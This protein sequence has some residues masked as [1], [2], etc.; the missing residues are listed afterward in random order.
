MVEFEPKIIAFC[1]HYCAYAAADLAG[2]M[3]MKYPPNVRIIRLPCTGKLDVVYL[4]KAFENKADGVMVV[5]CEKGS[6][7][8]TSGNLRAEKRVAYAKELLKEVGIE[9][10]RLEMYFLSSSMAGRFVQVVN[11][12]TERIKKLGPSL[13]AKGS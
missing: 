5:G 11:E 10:E 13:I 6:C 4:L 12:M 2:I 3:R 7:H 9:P 8:F 1:C